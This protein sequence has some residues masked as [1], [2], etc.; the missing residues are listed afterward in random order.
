MSANG[1]TET[2]PPL[3]S[4]KRKRDQVSYLDD[5]YFDELD[6]PEPQPEEDEDEV[7]N[8]EEDEAYGRK[9]SKKVAKTAKKKAKKTPK[10]K[11]VKPFRFL[12]LSAELRNE[13]YERALTEPD[14]LTL[15]SKS[16][17]NRRQ[18]QRGSI[19]V[20]RSDHYYGQAYR[21]GWWRRRHGKES[22]ESN[23]ERSLSPNL[24]ATNRQIRAEASSYLYK[25]E[26]IMADMHALQGFVANIGSYNRGL[27]NNITIRGWT[28]G[29][30][31]YAAFSM[32]QFCENLES[33]YFDCTL[34]WYRRPK[35][36]ARQIYRD[37]H[38]FLEN[39]SR[40]KGGDEDA[41]EIIQFGAW[42]FNNKRVASTRYPDRSGF[43]TV[44]GGEPEFDQDQRDVFDKELLKMLVKAT[45]R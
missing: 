33:L 13:I 27:V 42:H 43:D 17:D 9:R 41:V 35:V 40:L 23:R 7:S 10:A 3:R 21:R 24:L 20:T 6:L 16:T 15:I 19:T 39:M 31:N 44:G 45:K 4:S 2:A 1:A 18:I 36:L 37:A 22:V 11:K 38:I 5:D 32:L 26:I 25:Q 8:A 34:G 30:H 14:G 28:E 12:D 29:P